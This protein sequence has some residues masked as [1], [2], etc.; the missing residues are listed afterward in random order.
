MLFCKKESGFS[1]VELM[2]SMAI[3]GVLSA[4]SVPSLK[5]WSRNY[6]VQSAALDLYAHMHVAKLGAVKENRAWMI[7]FFT[8]GHF[9]SLNRDIESHR[10]HKVFVQQM[11]QQAQAELE[12]AEVTAVTTV[13]HADPAVVFT[14]RPQIHD[15]DIG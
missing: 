9:L 4:M 12:Q 14:E 2:V 10:N 3:I 13:D 6:N 7:N 8:T 5:G 15:P 1:I 11:L